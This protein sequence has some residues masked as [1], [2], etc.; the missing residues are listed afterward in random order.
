MESNENE[1]VEF[2]DAGPSSFVGLMNE[3]I[4]IKGYK[5][6]A[7]MTCDGELLYGNSAGQISSDLTL[8]AEVLNN[9]FGHAC[10]LAEKSGFISCGELSLQTGGDV[11]VINCSGQDCLVGIRLLVLVEEQGNIVIMRRKLGKLL[12]QIMQCL[13]WEPDNLVPLFMKESVWRQ[14]DGLA[15]PN[16]EVVTVN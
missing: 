6:S 8:L 1:V 11:V 10:I 16:A 12:P 15:S 4:D 14:K 5:A 3:L 13:T 2:F 7:I 9:F